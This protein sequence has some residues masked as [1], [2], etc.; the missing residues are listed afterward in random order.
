MRRPAHGRRYD[1]QLAEQLFDRGLEAPHHR[2]PPY[3]LDSARRTRRDPQ[4]PTLPAIRSLA[5][6]LPPIEEIP[7][8]PDAE[9]LDYLRGALTTGLPEVRRRHLAW[10]DGVR[11]L[12]TTRD[13]NLTLS[14]L[15]V[16]WVFLLLALSI[17]KLLF[18]SD[19]AWIIPR[20]GGRNLSPEGRPGRLPATRPS[21]W[22]PAKLDSSSAFH[23]TG[24]YAR[25]EVR[26]ARNPPAKPPPASSESA[27]SEPI[28]TRCR[29]GG[30]QTAAT[31]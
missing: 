3:L 24:I 16:P 8:Q 17:Y 28:R 18:V 29:L 13:N 1:R 21:S 5:Y 11:L 22:L 9:Y 15:L 7:Q 19:L 12:E 27:D 6:F 26:P 2:R 31:E 4:A 30:L 23:S 20:P 14:S 10:R 25:A